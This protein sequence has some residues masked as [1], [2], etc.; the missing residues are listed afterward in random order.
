M[1]FTSLKS[2]AEVASS[3][4]WAIPDSWHWGNYIDAADRGNLWL[5]GRHSLVLSLIKVPLGL[6]FASLA[7]YGLAILG[8]RRSRLVVGILAAGAMVP[9]QIALGPLF[10]LSLSLG[11]L[12]TVFGLIPPYLAF[13]IPYQVFMLYGFF[14]A[15]PRELIDAAR[16]DGASSMRI[17]ASIA[18]PSAKP[19]LAALFILDFV[20]TWNEF[21]IALTLLQ[22][23]QNH[24]VPLAVQ[25]FSSQFATNYEQLTAFIL[26]SAIPVLIVYV[27]FQRYFV[28]G[29]FA[30]SVKG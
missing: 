1:F 4:I 2:G 12:D 9:I 15:I 8:M 26:M 29:A 27:L 25:N 14:R 28:S 30:G 5:T 18:I 7:A 24:T 11:T 6:F 17:Y 21:P 19:A 16:L 20:A 22:S 3:A 10:N 23:Q 13:G